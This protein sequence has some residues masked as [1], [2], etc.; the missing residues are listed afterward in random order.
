MLDMFDMAGVCIR[1]YLFD[2]KE[3]AV[4]WSNNAEH[5]DRFDTYEYFDTGTYNVVVRLDRPN[6]DMM[7]LR[8]DFQ[9]DD[10]SWQSQ[11]MAI[12]KNYTEWHFRAF[13]EQL[14]KEFTL[15]LDSERLLLHATL[16]LHPK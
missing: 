10:P 8:A 16:V 9:G 1:L 15:S 11:K 7:L 12:W 13:L 2:R 3:K 5:L 4:L 6:D 14:G